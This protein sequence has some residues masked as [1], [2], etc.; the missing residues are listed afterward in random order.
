MLPFSASF[1]RQQVFG[2][3]VAASIYRPPSPLIFLA[4]PP[5]PSRGR[6]FVCCK[7]MDQREGTKK[8]HNLHQPVNPSNQQPLEAGKEGAK[9]SRE[10]MFEAYGD[11]YAT[12]SVEE[13]FGHAASEEG[14]DPFHESVKGDLAEELGIPE[15]K[16]R[17]ASTEKKTPKSE[18]DPKATTT[19]KPQAPRGS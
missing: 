10:F 4:P 16:N 14:M 12:R 15:L 8:E 1:L 19:T 2:S 3:A 5:P 9:S 7:A 18:E 6:S 17:G 13:G 11:K